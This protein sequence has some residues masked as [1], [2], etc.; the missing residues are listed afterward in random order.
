MTSC[1]F[2]FALPLLV[3]QHCG[4]PPPRHCWLRKAHHPKYVLMLHDVSGVRRTLVATRRKQFG[5]KQT[6]IRLAN[7]TEEQE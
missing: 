1:E 7:T 3:H 2:H 5:D 4:S 6:A